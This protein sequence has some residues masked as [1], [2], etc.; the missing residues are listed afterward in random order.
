MIFTKLKNIL[1]IIRTFKTL[2]SAYELWFKQIIFE[3]DIVRKLLVVNL[4]VCTLCFFLI[5]I[6]VIIERSRYRIR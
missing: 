3:M 5:L 2:I 1:F 6:H 4:W